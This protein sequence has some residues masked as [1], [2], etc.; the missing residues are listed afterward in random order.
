MRTDFLLF[1]M[2]YANDPLSL[3]K[4]SQMGSGSTYIKLSTLHPY[5]KSPECNITLII[6]I[7]V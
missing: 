5:H 3:K 2:E 4:K 6:F 7:Y 1:T